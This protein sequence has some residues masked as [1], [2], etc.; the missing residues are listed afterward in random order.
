[1]DG[2]SG[3][4]R[5]VAFL[6]NV[7]VEILEAEAPVLIRRFGLMPDSEGPGKFRGGFGI[8]FDIEMTRPGATLVMR[9]QDRHIFNPWG[10]HGGRAGGNAACYSTVDGVSTYLGKA[11]LHR[12]KV[13]EVVTIVG[14]GGGGYGDPLDRDPVRVLSDYLNG[15]V[16]AQR[17]CDC[18]G[19]VIN[20]SELDLDATE[21]LRAEMRLGLV[22][23]EWLDLGAARIAW[24]AKYGEAGKC[25]SDWVWSLPDGVRTEAK[26]YA[27]DS[28]SKFGD[29][30]Y[31]KA[32][33]DAI[34][35]SAGALGDRV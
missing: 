4:D 6:K 33:V 2:V 21:V 7:P 23:S 17:A 1:M 32:D 8:R 11:N 29:G 28:L 19:V 24:E 27:F 14:A 10:V 12:P 9:G 5:P 13:D 15:F 3:A 26:V 25:I 18:Y 34:I 35:S 31:T 16:S 20:E 22:N 30:P